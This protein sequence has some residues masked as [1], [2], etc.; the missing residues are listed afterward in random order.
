MTSTV[1]VQWSTKWGSKPTLSWSLC[2]F[3]ETREV[4]KWLLKPQSTSMIFIYPQSFIN[5]FIIWPLCV[6]ELQCWSKFCKCWR[7]PELYQC[8]WK[9][10]E[11]QG[12]ETPRWGKDLIRSTCTCIYTVT[13]LNTPWTDSQSRIV[14]KWLKGAVIFWSLLGVCARNSVQWEKLIHQ[15]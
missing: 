15:C 8:D 14:W 2:W 9:E 7:G 11:G 4:M 10:A 3:E 1:L 5:L 12:T 13:W 6:V